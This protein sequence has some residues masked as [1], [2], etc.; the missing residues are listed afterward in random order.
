MMLFE[1]I[2]LNRIECESILKLAKDYY[3]SSIIDN[4]GNVETNNGIRNSVES[5]IENNVDIELLLLS[6]LKKYNIKSLPNTSKIIKYDVG[7]FFK[8][9]NDKIIG[10]KNERILTLIIQ[11]S[12]ETNYDG[13][14]LIVDKLVCSKKIGNMIIFDSSIQ[15][16]V[17]E[18]I[19]G[20]RIAMVMWMER[21]NIVKEYII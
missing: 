10:L 20:S 2:I 14:N 8:P 17:T 12:D 16:E 15:H 4:I 18:I 11:L 21:D 19:R 5:T 6:K 1:E 9:H 7:C 3:K 13:G